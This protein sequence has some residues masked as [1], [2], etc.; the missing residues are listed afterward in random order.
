MQLTN[1]PADSNPVT[2]Q[3]PT[4]QANYE[5]FLNPQP[6][7]KRPLLNFKGGSFKKRLMIV[8]GGGIGLIIFFV[9][10]SSLLGG[11]TNFTTYIAVAQDQNE[12]IRVATEANDKANLQT[13][14]NFSQSVDTSLTSG[15]QQILSYL[16]INGQKVSTSQLGATENTETDQELAAATAASN[17][18]AVY[19]KV[20]ETGLQNY[21]NDL[22]LAYPTAKGGK[23]LILQDFNGAELLLTQAKSIAGSLQSQ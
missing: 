7:A 6:T 5:F 18:D 20:M 2:G 22:K 12:L 17:F 11:G 16:G 13:T 9:I 4:P 21:I 19:L 15:Q 1:Q 3:P 8:S 10:I 23:T 14:K